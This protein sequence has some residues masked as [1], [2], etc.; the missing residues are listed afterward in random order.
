MNAWLVN[1]V[2]LPL[3]PDWTGDGVFGIAP[4]TNGT[5]L[6]NS[7]PQRLIA[8]Y[9][10]PSVGIRLERFWQQLVR[11][12]SSQASRTD[13]RKSRTEAGGSLTFGGKPRDKCS[14]Q[15][16]VIHAVKEDEQLSFKT[17]ING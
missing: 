7:L 1:R 13:A 12:Y 17:T 3:N 9:G 16:S 8:G 4:D 2:D 10:Q 11:S 6:Q 14:D 5:A 15:W